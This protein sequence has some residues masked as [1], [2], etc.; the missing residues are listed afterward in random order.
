M[1]RR[2]QACRFLDGQNVRCSVDRRSN[3]GTLRRALAEGGVRT[4]RRSPA[5]KFQ[6]ST[7]KLIEVHARSPD[8]D[9]LRFRISLPPP[10]ASHQTFSAGLASARK[11]SINTGI[12]GKPLHCETRAENRNSLSPGVFL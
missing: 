10:V 5:S 3:L 7:A 12:S 1:D 2:G 6:R 4:V 8:F 11:T 9:V